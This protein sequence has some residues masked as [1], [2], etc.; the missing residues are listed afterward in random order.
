MANTNTQEPTVK[1]RAF[2][3]L[4]SRDLRRMLKDY[5]NLGDEWVKKQLQGMGKA[6]LYFEGVADALRQNDVGTEASYKKIQKAG[7]PTETRGRGNT[8][9]ITRS[10]KRRME[11]YGDLPQIKD[12]PDE[13]VKSQLQ[14]ANKGDYFYPGVAEDIRAGRL[15]NS[16]SYFGNTKLQDYLA[17]PGNEEAKNRV[18][19]QQS[20]PYAQKISNLTPEQQQLQ[21]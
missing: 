10:I 4:A 2:M 1:K 12:N 14:K 18:Y 5:P 16:A 13:Y 19:K 6:D 8:T 7:G 17:V 20:Q 11:K 3:G 21:S 9:D 15:S